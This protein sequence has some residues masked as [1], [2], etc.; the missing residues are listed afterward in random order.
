[1]PEGG[2]Q[3]QGSQL[4][5]VYHQNQEPDD[6]EFAP[7]KVG[8]LFLQQP[9]HKDIS[10]SLS[11]EEQKRND[12]DDLQRGLV[13]DGYV[14]VGHIH[15][16]PVARQYRESNLKNHEAFGAENSLQDVLKF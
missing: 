1:M 10:S 9:M 15:H 7:P 2:V 13:G 14:R 6:V 11:Q 16:Q 8:C 4:Q 12:S 5:Q 3:H